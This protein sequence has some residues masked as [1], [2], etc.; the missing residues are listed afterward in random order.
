[1]SSIGLAD[2]HLIIGALLRRRVKDVVLA[3]TFIGT[4]WLSWISLKPFEDLSGLHI[5]DVSLGNELPTYAAFGCLAVFAGFLASRDNQRALASLATPAFVLFGVWACITVS[6]SLDPSTSIRRFA[7]TLFVI[8]VTASMMLLPKTPAELMRWL[9]IA[10][11]GLLILCYLGVLLVP[12][13]SV[14]QATDPVEPALAGDWRGVFGHKNQAAAIM[15]M[16]LFLGISI[17]RSGGSVSGAIIIVLSSVFLMKSAGK[18]SLSLCVAVL[19]LT[20]MTT[21][22][23]SFW[24]RAIMLLAPLVLLNMFSVGTVISDS[25]AALAKLLP[26]D[27]SFTGRVDI[28]NF[29]VQSVQEHPIKGYGFSAFWGRGAVQEVPEGKEWTAFA[30][31]SHN[32]YLDTALS[33]GLPGLALLVSAIVI[34][35]LRN[36]HKADV[37]GNQKPLVMAL[38]QIWLFGIYLSCLE[39]FYLDRS[40]PLWVTFLLAIFGLHYLARFRVRED[41]ST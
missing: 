19:M 2:V 15:A 33:M 10:S 25:L 9:G 13:L 6:L 28:W 18:S 39:S 23:R 31:H 40:D 38:L 8:A 16:L 5:G 17:L 29:G 37:I 4:L 12:H 7:L 1:M 34:D 30:A 11:I 26:L 27:S 36:F 21:I 3:A 20:T 32:G 22:V 35:P 41:P 24:L 14:H